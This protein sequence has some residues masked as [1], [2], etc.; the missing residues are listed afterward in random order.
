MRPLHSHQIYQSQ[1]RETRPTIDGY[2]QSRY[3]IKQRHYRSTG[4]KSIYKNLWA[5]DYGSNDA[6]DRSIDSTILILLYSS[7]TSLEAL[8]AIQPTALLL[9]YPIPLLILYLNFLFL[10]QFSTFISFYSFNC[11]VKSGGVCNRLPVPC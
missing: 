8:R 5:D 11:T 1:Q 7:T 3:H 2:I 6:P 10:V 9:P 4:F